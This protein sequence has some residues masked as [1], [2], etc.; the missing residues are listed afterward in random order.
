M[1]GLLDD[2][3]EQ[4]ISRARLI[5]DEFMKERTKDRQGP[6]RWS[7]LVLRV[8]I[9]DQ[10]FSIQWDKRIWYAAQGNK[11]F[12]YQYLSTK[13]VLAHASDWEIDEVKFTR[14]RLVE[15]VHAYRELNKMR[16]RMDRLALLGNE[17][18]VLIGFIPQEALSIQRV[19]ANTDS[20]SNRDN[21]C[22]KS[23]RAKEHRD[24]AG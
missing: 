1:R 13:V 7:D 14:D 9:R 10:G 23:F 5:T 3:I 17:A 18:E 4:I 21:E 11:R 12:R 15:L 22:H 24:H 19:R 8:R 20:V 16:K 2:L 6:G